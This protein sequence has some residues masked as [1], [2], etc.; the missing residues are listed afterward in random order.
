[1]LK[2]IF[3]D[4][5]STKIISE[6]NFPPL[7]A[8]CCG[9]WKFIFGRSG[10]GLWCVILQI[11]VNNSLS[12]E[13][14]TY[15]AD[16]EEQTVV[17]VKSVPGTVHLDL[18]LVASNEGVVAV[19]QVQGPALDVGALRCHLLEVKG[20]QVN[21]KLSISLLHIAQVQVA[22]NYCQ[23]CL[24]NHLSEAGNQIRVVC[25]GRPVNVEYIN[26]SVLKKQKL[27]WS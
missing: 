11:T 13:E 16:G 15:Q 26:K 5:T 24:I 25:S 27:L 6:T 7:A 18:H 12:K 8:S 1:M 4:K 22:G 21:E 19:D 17:I 3:T 10:C 9:H 20:I 23:F 14:V 2:S